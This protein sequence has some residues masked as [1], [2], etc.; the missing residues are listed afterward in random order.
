MDL[1][2]SPRCLP[3]LLARGA[4]ITAN[5]ISKSELDVLKSPSKITKIEES[6]TNNP[7]NTWVN[8]NLSCPVRASIKNVA[9]TSPNNKIL[10]VTGSEF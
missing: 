7:P 5:T 10:I 2:E 8:E 9:G 4:E 3:Y 1:R 6:T